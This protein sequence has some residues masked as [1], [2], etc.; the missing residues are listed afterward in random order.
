MTIVKWFPESIPSCSDFGVYWKSPT[1][2]AL[3]MGRFRKSPASLAPGSPKALTRWL[4][5]ARRSLVPAKE[6]KFGFT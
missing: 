4:V 3:P 6:N 5:T 1:A 2:T